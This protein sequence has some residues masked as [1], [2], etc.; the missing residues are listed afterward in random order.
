MGLSVQGRKMLWGRSGNQCSF[1]DC[2]FELAQANDSSSKAVV[3][4]EE[5]H[6]V[7]QKSDGP[8]GTSP[9]TRDQRDEYSNLILLCPTHHSLVDADETRFPVEVL[10]SMKAAHEDS[11]RPSQDRSALQ[12]D[13]QWARII[14]GL[15][16]RLDLDNW[17]DNYTGFFQG[18]EVTLKASFV[19]DAKAALVWLA[20][21]PWPNGHEKLKNICIGTGLVLNELLCKLNENSYEVDVYIKYRT[22]YK[23]REWNEPLYNQLLAEYKLDRSLM[24]DL[25]LELTRHVNWFSDEVRRQIDP[26]FRFEEGYCSLT[27]ADGFGTALLT[28]RFTR[29]E[30]QQEHPFRGIKAFMDDRRTR[31]T[32]ASTY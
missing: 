19:K 25:A 24:E 6:I 9:L 29:Q 14:D 20:K 26:D 31:S 7:A 32:M 1:T 30:V 28:P 18:G 12:S 21:R 16:T 2:T 8:R 11:I 27:T 4:G 5:A 23:I 10:L 13:E 22:Y 15:T 3:I 17:D